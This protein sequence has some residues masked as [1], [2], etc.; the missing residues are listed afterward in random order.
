MQGLVI[1]TRIAMPDAVTSDNC[2]CNL[3]LFVSRASYEA[4]VVFGLGCRKFGINVVLR[5]EGN[6]QL[7]E[8]PELVHEDQIS[9]TQILKACII[10]IKMLMAAV[11]RFSP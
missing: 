6:S 4:C 7:L 1:K 3:K 10:L 9:T 11:C 2:I 5:N 8:A